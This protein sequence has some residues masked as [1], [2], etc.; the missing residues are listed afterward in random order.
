MG[1]ARVFYFPEQVLEW[2]VTQTAGPVRLPD[3][4]LQSLE[5]HLEPVRF[6][7]AY[8]HLQGGIAISF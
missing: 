4:L 3:E 7:P 8:F 5:Q 6:N 1:D 2:R